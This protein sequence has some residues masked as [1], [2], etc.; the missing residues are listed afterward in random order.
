ML[1]LEDIDPG[2]QDPRIR[3]GLVDDLHWF[4]LEWDQLVWQS[5][6]RRGHEEA[7]ETLAS[8][9]LLY[10]CGCS[11]RVVQEAGVPSASGG[12]VY[13]G[14]CRMRR[15]RNWR[16]SR[17]GLRADLTDLKVS[18]ADETGTDLSQVLGTAM[19]DPLVRRP[20]GG[21]TYQLAVVVDDAA[22][23]VTRVVRG[24]DIATSTATQAAL[25]DLLGLKRPVWRHHLLL[26][27]TQGK[28]LA[29]LHQSVAVPQLQDFYTPQ[30]LLGF[31]A[32]ACGLQSTAHPVGLQQLLAQFAWA[33]VESQDVVVAWHSGALELST[34]EL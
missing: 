8:L 34:S 18:V 1:R 19:G 15:V 13:P 29:K 4:G 9:G 7:L 14:T 32:K 30:A 22:A 25:I 33:R 24:R 5:E 31:L 6:G 10:E 26:L 12:W 23:G 20:D 17:L 2:A 16:A 27:E 28:K 3:Q 21:A 11:R